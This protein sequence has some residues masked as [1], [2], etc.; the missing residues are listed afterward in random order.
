MNTMEIKI[1]RTNQSKLNTTDF[2]NLV[3]GKSHSDHMFVM[4]YKDGQ[5]QTPEII[6]YQPFSY[7]PNLAV[8]HYGQSVFEGLK[9]F[10]NAETGLIQMFRPDEHIARFNISAARLCM[11]E[12]DEEIF[13]SALKQLITLDKDWV[14]DKEGNSLY[15]RPFMI[16]T[17]ESLGVVPSKTYKFIIFTSPASVYYAEPVRLKVESEFVR[18]AEG[19]IGFAKSG[20]NYAAS[21]LPAKKALDEG[22]NQ[23]LWTD[24]KEH[25]YVEEAGTMNVMFQID[26]VLVTPKLSTSILSGITRKSVIDLARHWGYIVEER[27]I[28]VQEVLT[29]ITEERLQDAF[30]TGTAVTIH[31]IVTIGKDG[32][33]YELPEVKEREFSNKVSDYLYKLKLGQAEDFMSWMETV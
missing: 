23:V 5:W 17:D 18:S 32:R 8:F 31:E 10:K 30:G 22:Y 12:V 27:Q 7:E 1:T 21:L 20:G 16:A 26:E 24:S 29:A 9:A 25:K 11:P 28:E 6:P 15:I 4:D 2:D 14:S 33:D 19:G 3:F 13:M